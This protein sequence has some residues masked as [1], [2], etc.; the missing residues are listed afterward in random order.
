MPITGKY[1]LKTKISGKTIHEIARVCKEIFKKL[2]EDAGIIYNPWNNVITSEWEQTD[3]E[4][5]SEQELML[6]KNRI[7]G[8]DELSIFCR[9]LF[10]VATVTG[11]TEGDIC[12]L[13]WSE[14]SWVTRMIFRKRRKTKVDLAVPILSALES[15]LKSLPRNSEYVF[16]QHADMYLRDASLI[17]YRIKRFLKSLGIKTTKQFKDRKSI[18]VKDLHSMRHVFC[19]Y[20]GQAGISL[21]VV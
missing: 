18:S 16:P 11:L 15:Y 12:T 21:A 2:Q 4:I 3:R 6:I 1:R 5:F 17:S 8:D 7:K 14:I 10:L 19:Y 9:P 20:A 13:K